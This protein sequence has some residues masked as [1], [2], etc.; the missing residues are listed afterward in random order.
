MRKKDAKMK[1]LFYLVM[2]LI[3][4]I[5]FLASSPLG[6]IEEKWVAK[7]NGP[8]NSIDN[9]RAIAFDSSGNVYVAGVSHGSGTY[10]DYATIAYDSSG[11]QLW[12]A[13]YNGPANL[14][15]NARAIAV[16]SSGNIYVTGGSDGSG[17]H[18][19]YATVAYDSSGNQLW[20]AR[21]NG[22]G[23]WHDYAQAI[24]VSSS[25]NVYVTGW[26]YGSWGGYFDD[27]YDYATIA[28]DSSGNQLWVARYNGPANFRDYAEAIAVDSSGNVY[29]AGGSFGSETSYDYATV[30]YDS[31]GSQLWVARYN[32][33]ANVD[34]YAE[35]IAVDSSGNVYVTGWIST[36]GYSDYATV[37]YFNPSDQIKF[38]KNDAGN[39][40]AASELN[41]VYE[42][43]GKYVKVEK[44]ST[45][46]SSLDWRLKNGRNYMTSVKDQRNCG[47]CWAHAVIGT[48]EAMYNVEREIAGS[49]H[50]LQYPDL[51]EKELV[52]CSNCGDCSGGPR[53]NPGICAEYI[54]YNG[55]VN[56][57]CFPYRGKDGPCEK[58]FDWSEKL[59]FITDWDWVT[60]GAANKDAI[61]NAIQDGPLCFWMQVY[62]DFYDYRA[63][64]YEPP[65]S[66]EPTGPHKVILVGYNEDEDYWIC[67]NSWGKDWGEDGYFRIKMGVPGTG[68]WVLKLWGVLIDDNPPVLISEIGNQ[69]VKEGQKF[70]TQLSAYDTDDDPLTFSAY[71]LPSGASMNNDVFSWTPN[72]NQSGEYYIR[73]SVND[74]Q[75]ED[76]EDVKITVL[77]ASDEEEAGKKK[78]CFVATAAYG[79][80]FHSYVKILRDFRDTYLM[81]GKLG[82]TLVCFYYK[83]SPF[84]AD[85]IAKHKVLKV[86]VRI[87]LLPL[88]VLSY[89]MVYF[90]PTITAIMLVLIFA[91]PVF[92]ISFFR[93][94]ISRV[95]AKAH[96]ALASRI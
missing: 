12:V 22:P 33:P 7:Y 36:T 73:F 5:L 41:Q 75:L 80:Q 96:K 62:S 1:K 35:A 10:N 90:G 39:F 93:R 84:V 77:N 95:E 37:K 9:A 11:N 28:Y 58:C 51:S 47:S 55:I 61:I 20:V 17:T 78:G 65:A 32:G 66:A 30:A 43:H 79:S 13:R 86:T 68:M 48:M 82:R 76:F 92:V 56:E 16:D 21:Y 6:Y 88:V 29:V 70:S 69:T 45:L 59:A 64:I 89:S 3:V 14:H 83:Y 34:D 52:S 87:N 23:N 60:Q 18:C 74:S 46:P 24:A 42:D 91:L 54:K 50:A 38:V 81:P 40:A 85:L 15:D 26:S 27:E 25:G 71:P 94:R 67:K 8:A 53:W 31:S 4:G 63:G 49:Q 72:Y 2:I 44:R 57:E 19:D